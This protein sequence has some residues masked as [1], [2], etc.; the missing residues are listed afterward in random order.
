M[1]VL[2]SVFFFFFLPS[3]AESLAS[4]AVIKHVPRPVNLNVCVCL[5]VACACVSL[6]TSAS[7]GAKQLGIGYV[8]DTHVFSDAHSVLALVANN[9]SDANAFVFQRDVAACVHKLKSLQDY[10]TDEDIL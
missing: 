4:W 7:F 10:H 1:S 6:R 9:D 2:S 3:S 8:S 5:C